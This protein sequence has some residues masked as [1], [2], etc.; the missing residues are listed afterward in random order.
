MPT[1]ES[2]LN[3]AKSA[4]PLGNHRRAQPGLASLRVS[5]PLPLWVAAADALSPL[6]LSHARQHGDRPRARI[7]VRLRG[8]LDPSPGAH[9]A[10]PPTQDMKLD[11]VTR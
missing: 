7:F 9:L 4:P 2:P 1:S 8:L 10:V 11:K 6:D 3:P 5:A